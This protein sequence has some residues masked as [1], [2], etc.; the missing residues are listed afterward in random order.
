MNIDKKTIKD[1]DD[2]AEALPEMLAGQE[3]ELSE[4]EERRANLFEDINVSSNLIDIKIES[5][6]GMCVAM[7]NNNFI[8]LNTTLTEELIKEGIAREV[9]SKVQ[10]LRKEK[11]FDIENRIKLYYN[12]DSYF[13]EVLEEFGDYIKDEILAIEI[14]KDENLTNKFD[15]N[16]I[17]VYLDVERVDN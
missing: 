1:A 16:D 6:D 14:I 11:D 5:K 8:I 13:E 9:I 3:Q 17:E 4:K 10:N 12:S 7:E 15:I 2:L